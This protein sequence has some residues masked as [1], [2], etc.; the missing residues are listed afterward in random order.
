M[1]VSIYFWIGFHLFIFTMLAIDLGVFHKKTHVVP[2]KEAILWSSIWILLALLFD[3]FVFF[4]FGK[5]KA[6]EF[7]TG[8]V[9][10]YSLSVDNIF[11]F[12][13]IFTYF[14]LLY[15]SP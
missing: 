6:L 9:I 2:V 13:M 1:G 7:F 4:E 3:L 12:I 11:V 5:T 10:E 14:C 15:T 8:Y